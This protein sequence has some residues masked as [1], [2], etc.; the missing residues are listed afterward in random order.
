M[1]KMHT[2]AT[3]RTTEGYIRIWNGQEWLSQKGYNRWRNSP[4]HTHRVRIENITT[5]ETA[6]KAREIAF[7]KATGNV[8]YRDYNDIIK[9]EERILFTVP[10]MNSSQFHRFLVEIGIV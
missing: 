8:N 10:S 7:T 3:K 4:N 5:V 6:L 9:I 1:K 2:G